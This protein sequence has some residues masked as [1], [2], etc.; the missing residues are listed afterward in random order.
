M[1]FGHIC[2]NIKQHSIAPALEQGFVGS[3]YALSA[4]QVH[5][6][7]CT[8]WSPEVREDW[9]LKQTQTVS[10]PPSRDEDFM[11]VNV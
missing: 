7:N 11:S 3:L 1:R 5:V 6:K 10:T 8:C 2:T 9:N 4:E